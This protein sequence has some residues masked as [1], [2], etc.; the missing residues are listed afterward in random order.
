VPGNLT[1]SGKREGGNDGL[2]VNPH[3]HYIHRYSNW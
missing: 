1:R 2:F 3:S